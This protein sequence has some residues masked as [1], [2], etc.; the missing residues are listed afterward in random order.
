MHTR[1]SLWVKLPSW[2][3]TSSSAAAA[4]ASL[5]C[6]AVIITEATATWAKPI[7]PSQK[8]RKLETTTRIPITTRTC[9][10]H[11]FWIDTSHKAR[12]KTVPFSTKRSKTVHF[13]FCSFASHTTFSRPMRET[14]ACLD[15]LHK[16]Y[17]S[18]CACLS[19]LCLITLSKIPLWLWKL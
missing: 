3:A 1:R 19:P 4:W 8:T 2:V 7:A 10:G 13:T 17:V 6:C 9:S 5:S 11:E 18:L 16:L 12:P 14:C 15:L